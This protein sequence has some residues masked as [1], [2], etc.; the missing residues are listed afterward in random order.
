[1]RATVSAARTASMASTSP[2]VASPCRKLGQPTMSTR[3]GAGPGAWW[4]LVMAGPRVRGLARRSHPPGSA[5]GTGTTPHAGAGGPGSLRASTKTIPRLSRPGGWARPP[6]PA[7]STG[8]RYR[9]TGCR[10]HAAS[11]PPRAWGQA[12]PAPSRG[13]ARPRRTGSLGATAVPAV[14]AGAQQHHIAGADRP[15]CVLPGGEFG[16]GDRRAGAP[17][18]R[19]VQPGH[20]DHVGAP[21]AASSGSRSTPM[22]PAGP[23]CG[24]WLDGGGMKCRGASICVPVCSSITSQRVW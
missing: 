10:G 18:G 16:H 23:A 12:S 13:P 7:R 4:L 8:R 6:R 15:V 24:S 3:P 9:R 22:S 21:A 2:A 11:R 14:P 1:M 17:A 20:V 5:A 19:P